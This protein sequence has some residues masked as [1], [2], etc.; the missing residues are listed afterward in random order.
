M[1]DSEREIF[2]VVSH[3]SVLN[4]CPADLLQL[5][6]SSFEDGIANAISSFKCQK[7]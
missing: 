1:S 4:P 2:H 6:F 5:N 7:I 3:V